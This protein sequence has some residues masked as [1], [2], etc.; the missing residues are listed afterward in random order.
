M[1]LGTAAF[2]AAQAENHPLN[3]W[4]VSAVNFTVSVNH[5]VA[6]FDSSAQNAFTGAVLGHVAGEN[7]RYGMEIH[8]IEAHPTRLSHTNFSTRFYSTVKGKDQQAL[9]EDIAKQFYYLSN[10]AR[11]EKYEEEQYKKWEVKNEAAKKFELENRP[12]KYTEMTETEDE[13]VVVDENAGLHAQY[14]ELIFA[15]IDCKRTN[16][17]QADLPVWAKTVDFESPRFHAQCHDDDS[18]S[19]MTVIGLFCGGWVV[20]GTFVFAFILLCSGSGKAT[21]AA[22]GDETVMAA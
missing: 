20:L 15:E 14:E 1:M 10:E 11:W 7:T 22:P 4:T 9:V 6:A 12:D 21:K 3:K 16:Y 13:E 8:N 18:L 2:A 5:D 19:S 17:D